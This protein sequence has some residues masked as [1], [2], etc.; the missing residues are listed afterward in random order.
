MSIKSAKDIKLKHNGLSTSIYIPYIFHRVACPGK[1]KMNNYS[2]VL[3]RSEK[4]KGYK[5]KY[6]LLAAEVRRFAGRLN[7]RIC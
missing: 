4:R 3:R 2:P 1:Y 6:I 7:V 5:I